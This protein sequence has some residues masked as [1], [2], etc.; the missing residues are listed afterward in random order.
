[1]VVVV[2][3]FVLGLAWLP[4]G[5]APASVLRGSSCPE[6]G[7]VEVESPTDRLPDADGDYWALLD[8]GSTHGWFEERH[9][10][11]QLP[12][13]VRFRLEWDSEGS[14]LAAYGTQSD[15]CMAARV[16]AHDR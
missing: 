11:S 15:V 3:A 14:L 8:R 1:V 12:W 2:V 4:G 6:G 9:L 7:D 5:V 16:L 13:R 10:K